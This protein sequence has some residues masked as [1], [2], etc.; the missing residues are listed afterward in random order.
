MRPVLEKNGLCPESCGG[1]SRSPCHR[2]QRGTCCDET[3]VRSS[4]VDCTCEPEGGAL[5]SSQGPSWSWPHWLVGVLVDMR[6]TSA[7]RQGGRAVR[8]QGPWSRGWRKA[9]WPED[10]SWVQIWGLV[11]H[12]DACPSEPLLP[13]SPAQG[14]GPPGH[15][16]AL[17]T[18]HGTSRSVLHRPSLP[19][20][21]RLRTPPPLAC[22]DPSRRGLVAVGPSEVGPGSRSGWDG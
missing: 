21:H 22:P 20:C 17:L 1:L 15:V 9:S 6:R 18:L 19:G 8:R 3:P 10:P 11:R 4:E 16:L 7:G 2:H 14:R 12:S 13:F 5:G